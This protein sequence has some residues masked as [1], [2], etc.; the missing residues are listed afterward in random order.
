[1]RA[2]AYVRWDRCPDL[3]S[4]AALGDQRVEIAM[5]RTPD[6]CARHTTRPDNSSFER[7]C[8][9][10]NYIGAMVRVSV[11]VLVP[12]LL[13]A[14]SVTIATPATVG[15]PVIRPLATFMARPAGK[16]IAS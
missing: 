6:G 3:F 4:P 1:M 13:V 11:A 16:P 2:V 10:F 12:P 15:V 5:M 8:G 9:R 14:L 7:W